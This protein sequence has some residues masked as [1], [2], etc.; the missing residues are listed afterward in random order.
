MSGR[1][2]TA[3]EEGGRLLFE[4]AAGRLDL[5]RPNLLGPHQI[6]NAGAALAALRALGLGDGACAAAVAQLKT[7]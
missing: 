5:P 3:R 2:W 4:D 6:D 1:D 7:G